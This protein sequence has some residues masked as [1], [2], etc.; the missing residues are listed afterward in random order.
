VSINAQR[1]RRDAER[2]LMNT[3]KPPPL[4]FVRGKGCYLYDDR[5]RTYLDF[6][7]G[8]AVN[9]LGYPHP[10][11][12]RTLRREAA[13]ATHLSNFFHNR[14]RTVLRADMR[15]VHAF[16]YAPYFEGDESPGLER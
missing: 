12:V 1:A 3:Y 5:G 10:R 8:I 16:K 15:I 11:L 2:Y 7:G 14:K 6:L 4:V 13:R 9:A